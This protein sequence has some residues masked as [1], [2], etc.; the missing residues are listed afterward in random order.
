MVYS[1]LSPPPQKRTTKSF[2]VGDIISLSLWWSKI[3]RINFQHSSGY[4]ILFIVCT[5]DNNLTMETCA[6]SGSHGI[7]IYPLITKT[8]QTNCIL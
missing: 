5:D 3:F 7:A 1:T 4:G 8:N 6:R 2:V